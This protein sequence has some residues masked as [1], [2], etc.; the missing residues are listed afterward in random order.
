MDKFLKQFFLLALTVGGAGTVVLYA[1]HYAMVEEDLLRYCICLA[2]TILIAF[3]GMK[4][5][6]QSL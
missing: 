1:L 2:A 3:T 6:E 4:C 5:L